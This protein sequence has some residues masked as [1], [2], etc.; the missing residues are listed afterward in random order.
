MG[1]G[2]S[3]CIVEEDTNSDPTDARNNDLYDCVNGFYYDADAGRA[4]TTIVGMEAALTSDGATTGGNINEDISAC[5]DSEFRFG[6]G[7]SL[8]DYVFDTLGL[9]L[10]SLFTTDKDVVTRTAILG[11]GWSMGPF[12]YD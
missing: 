11:R 10:D 4:L 6:S 3:I 8:A 1:D 9:D 7:C 2:T 5:L 12:E